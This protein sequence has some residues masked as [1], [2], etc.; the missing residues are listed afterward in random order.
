[1]Q[2]AV[3]VPSDRIKIQLQVQGRA[4][5]SSGSGVAPME[6]SVGAVRRCVATLVQQDGIRIG[7]FRG[8]WPTL[9]RQVPSGAVYYSTFES[10]KRQLGD[11]VLST[12]TAGGCAGCAG[13]I[14]TYPLDVLKSAAMAVRVYVCVRFCL[15]LSRVSPSTHSTHP[16][17]PLLLACTHVRY[18]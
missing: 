13:Y 17:E 11:G 10:L 2:C 3:I 18:A 14:S 12:A 5:Q 1:V 4:M 6:T 9:L 7:L 16:N 15:P 8:L